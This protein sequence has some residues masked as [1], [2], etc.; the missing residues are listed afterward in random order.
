MGA[1]GGAIPA[2]M[3]PPD[4]DTRCF[5]RV[6]PQSGVLCHVAQTGSYTWL[7]RSR[8]IRESRSV[9]RGTPLNLGLSSIFSKVDVMN[10]W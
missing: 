6:S 3:G 7:S 4:G 10:V 2:R 1:S 8:T 5:P 9:T